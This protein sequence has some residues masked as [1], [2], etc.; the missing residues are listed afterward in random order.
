MANRAMYSATKAA[1]EALVRSWADAFG[2]ND[3]QFEFMA[4][5][6]ANAVLVGLTKTDAVHRL[7]PGGF[8]SLAAKYVTQQS[9]PRIAEAE[10]VADVVGLLCSKEARWMTGSVIPANGGIY[11]IG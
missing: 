11:K 9:I 10:E 3:P 7:P 6:T 5:T 1:G 2:G 4:G 8:E